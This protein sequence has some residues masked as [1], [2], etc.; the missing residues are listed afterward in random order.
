MS[1]DSLKLK[2]KLIVG[3]AE[4][5]KAV[6]KILPLLSNHHLL[7]CTLLLYNALANEA[8]PIFLDALVPSWAAVLISVTLV[9]LCGEVIPTALFT[10]PNQLQIA[11][12]FTPL[13]Y[14][15]QVLF[16]PIAYPMAQALDHIL[17][18]HACIITSFNNHSLLLLLN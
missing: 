4:E 6:A 16:L 1:L 9:L 11:S 5:K 17:G 7:L 2:I 3:T 10:G 18:R 12:R 8:L 13:V 15:L 14:F